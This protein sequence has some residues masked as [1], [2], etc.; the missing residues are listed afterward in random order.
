[1]LGASDEE[2]P[3]AGPQP[4]HVTR[5]IIRAPGNR[6]NSR[7]SVIQLKACRLGA[8]SAPPRPIVVDGAA[9]RGHVGSMSTLVLHPHRRALATIRDLAD[10][11]EERRHPPRLML[12]TA[13]QI[14]DLVRCAA[15]EPAWYA[16]LGGSLFIPGVAAAIGSCLG[17][18]KGPPLTVGLAAIGIAVVMFLLSEARKGARSRRLH[19]ALA[20]EQPPTRYPLVGYVAWRFASRPALDVELCGLVDSTVVRDAA[21][22]FEPTL[23]ISWPADDVLRIS[24]TTVDRALLQ[25]LIDQVLTPLDHECGIA[26]VVMG[27][28]GLSA[29]SARRSDRRADL[30]TRLDPR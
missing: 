17:G 24:M 29:R 8:K 19:A 2:H 20:R 21:H 1:M 13:D 25:D 9:A 22:V 30:T 11:A 27:D 16:Y 23:Q 28:E 7:A 4:G 10:L 6:A 18:R 5:D 14:D 15:G 12:P 26:R 3:H